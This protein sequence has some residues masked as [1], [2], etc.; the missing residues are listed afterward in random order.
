VLILGDVRLYRD[1]LV[2]LLSNHH[3]LDVIGAVPAGADVA[4]VAAASRPD[5]V[6]IDAAAVRGSDLVHHMLSD[7]PGLRVVAYG[8][9]DEDRE[10][11]DCAEAGVAGYVRSD[12][13]RDDLIATVLG[14]ADGEFHCAPRIVTLVFKRVST[15]AADRRSTVLAAPLTTRQNQIIDLV[16]RGLGNKDIASRLGIEVSTVK[17]HIH[18]ILD[19]LHVARRGEAAAA[20]RRARVTTERHRI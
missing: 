16:D 18:N 3:A 5:I 15:L 1:G 19:K 12:A 2:S 7:V 20:V 11:L 6:L 10:A 13:T 14:V 9:M 8:L 17:N 4:Q